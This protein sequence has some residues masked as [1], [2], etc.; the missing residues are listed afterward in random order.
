MALLDINLR[1]IWR[2]SLRTIEIERSWA[3]TAMIRE[4]L[5]STW[6]KIIQPGTIQ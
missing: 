4:Q 5:A 2:G 1:T 3:V 6:I